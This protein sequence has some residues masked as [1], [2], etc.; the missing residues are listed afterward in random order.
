MFHYILVLYVLARDR[1]EDCIHHWYI[2]GMIV[3]K[4]YGIIGTSHIQEI[5]LGQ[6]SGKNFA[7]P[8]WHPRRYCTPCRWSDHPPKLWRVLILTDVGRGLIQFCL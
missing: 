5:P 8:C 3:A 7:R 2:G 4:S 6:V 1:M